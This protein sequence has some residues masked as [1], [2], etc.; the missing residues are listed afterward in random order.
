MGR[1][2]LSVEEVPETF[3]FGA[4][5]VQHLPGIGLDRKSVV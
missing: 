5:F 3:E 4:Q 1:R 2:R